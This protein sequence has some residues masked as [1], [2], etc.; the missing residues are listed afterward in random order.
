MGKEREDASEHGELRRVVNAVL[1]MFDA[2]EG[3]SLIIAATN[4]EGMLD[5]AIWRRFEEVLFFKPPTTA[6][7]RRLLSV[8]LRGVRHEFTVKEVADRGWFKGATHADVER[9][10]RRAVKEMVLQDGDLRLRLDHLEMARCRERAR[11]QRA[12]KS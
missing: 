11:K 4:H 6:Q 10:V 5:T 2:Y 8:Q 7:F 12:T 1:Q 9:V 3:R